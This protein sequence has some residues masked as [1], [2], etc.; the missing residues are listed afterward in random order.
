MESYAIGIDIDGKE[1]KI[2]L[3]HNNVKIFFY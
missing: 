1:H 3:P 2:K